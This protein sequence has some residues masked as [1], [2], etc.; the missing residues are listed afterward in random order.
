MWAS[1]VASVLVAVL[2]AWWDREN[3]RAAVYRQV[4]RQHATRAL[5]AMGWKVDALAH[6][7]RGGRLRDAGGTLLPG[8]GPGA[9]GPTP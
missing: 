7:D 3:F 6:P 8:D 9:P 5:A 2:R 4:E 1:L